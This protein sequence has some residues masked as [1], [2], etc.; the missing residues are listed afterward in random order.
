MLHYVTP[1]TASERLQQKMISE[2]VEK[3]IVAEV[4]NGVPEY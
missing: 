3:S 2:N 1:F 4:G